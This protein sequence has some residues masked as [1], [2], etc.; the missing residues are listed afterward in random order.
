MSLLPGCFACT[1]ALL[2]ATGD[3]RRLSGVLMPV[4]AIFSAT[5][6]NDAEPLELASVLLRKSEECGGSVGE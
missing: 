1:E 6:P 3:T 2:P 5:A 4:A